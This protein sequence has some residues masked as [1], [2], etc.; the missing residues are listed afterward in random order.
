MNAVTRLTFGTIGLACLTVFGTGFASA[1]STLSAGHGLVL[2]SLGPAALMMFVVSCKTE[3][4]KNEIIALAVMLLGIA[5]AM[6][7]GGMH[8]LSDKFAYS[9]FAWIGL[10]LMGASV[11]YIVRFPTPPAR[12]T[13]T[14]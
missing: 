5:V 10:M 9:F 3:T 8:E 7:M 14:C 13:S 11:Y 1:W 2:G 6:A 4:N 12:P